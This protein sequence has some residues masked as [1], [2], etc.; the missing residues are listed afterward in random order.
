MITREKLKT[1]LVADYIKEREKETILLTMETNG[2][3]VSYS[4]KINNVS[5]KICCSS[6]FSSSFTHSFFAFVF[7]LSKLMYQ[8]SVEKKHCCFR[9]C[10]LGV[11]LESSVVYRFL[12][13]QFLLS[14]QN[15][16]LFSFS[17]LT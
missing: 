13:L 6:S 11:T 12:I 4:Q 10:G 14:D 1:C 5:V 15:Q 17:F 7:F 9:S 2:L 16:K 8:T 3:W